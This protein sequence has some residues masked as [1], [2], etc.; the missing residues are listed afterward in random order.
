MWKLVADVFRVSKQYLSKLTTL[1]NH[2]NNEREKKLTFLIAVNLKTRT[3]YG[4]NTSHCVESSITNRHY[5][6]KMGEKQ[7]L[8]LIIIRH[9][10]GWTFP[11]AP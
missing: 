5:E 6:L 8:L 4:Q 11:R 1:F 7:T 2:L 10:N 3:L 9:N